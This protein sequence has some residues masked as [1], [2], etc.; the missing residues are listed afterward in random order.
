MS[1]TEGIL[2]FLVKRSFPQGK[3]IF[4]QTGLGA[5]RNPFLIKMSN[6]GQKFSIEGRVYVERSLK[7]H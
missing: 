3:I 7:N 1:P 6:A 4:L 5:Y 2:T